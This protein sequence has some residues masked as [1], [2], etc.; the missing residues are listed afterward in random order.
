MLKLA[1]RFLPQ[2]KWEVIIGQTFKLLEAVLEI[3]VPVVMAKIVDVG[4]KGRAGES[5][6]YKMGGILLLLAVVGVG[7]AII[8]QYLASKASQ[9]VGTVIRN[10]LFRKV[11]SFSYKNV[12]KFGT[13]SIITRITSDVNQFQNSVAMYIRLATRAPF[14]IFGSAVMAMTIDLKLSA[15]F[16]VII[17]LVTLILYTI[18]SKSV[19]F[20]SII[21]SA[22]DKISLR[23]RETLSGVRVIR[24]FSKQ[25]DE[26]VKFTETSEE[27]LKL[28]LR[29]GKLS[30]LL[31]PLTYLILNLAI[32][33]ILIFG[34]F[35]VNIGELTQG[36][37][38]AF[39]NYM[40]QISLTLIVVANLVLLFTKGA[41][42]AARINEILDTDSEILDGKIA[43]TSTSGNIVVEFKNVSFSYYDNGEMEL[44][45]IT[46]SALKGETVGIIGGTGSGKTTLVN[47]ICRFYDVS[48]G[49]VFIS[50]KNIRD[51]KL[52]V[53]REK[54]AVVPQ[55]AVLFSG[56]L[57][58]NLLLGNQNA[59]DEELLKAIEISQSTSV[60]ENLPN[61]LDSEI[62]QGGK[63]LSGGQ[64][65]RLTIARAIVCNSEILILDDSASALD[66]ATEAA[67]R[68]A[69]ATEIKN[70]T[71][72]IV[73]QR[74]NSLKDADKIIVL[75][76][77]KLVGI[78]K[79]SELLENCEFYKEIC[80]SQLSEKEVYGI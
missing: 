80:L 35:Q 38:I 32:V 4:I 59:T 10:E 79:H 34:G 52:S 7:F 43:E 15:I 14:I 44:N 2:Y 51:Y 26:E 1:K 49:E 50:E 11:N 70:T 33:A 58:E 45:D 54:I 55:K 36:E 28:S 78:G 68:K 47:L 42:S 17:V 22:L 3:F 16:L 23:T 67:L 9:G 19:R 64:K 69:I 63:N 41:A 53:L 6:I 56:T 73:S 62:S 57:R 71:V 20:Y 25:K 46:F 21:Q 77:G 61:G 66:F 40:T 29:V 65:Q 76:D 13:P 48:S 72:F 31:N 5:Y 74:V 37:I 75:D 18:M 30:A 27:Y 24:A 39:I 12:D 8:C 60:L